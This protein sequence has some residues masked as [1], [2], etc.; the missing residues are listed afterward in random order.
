MSARDTVTNYTDG[1]ATNGA[2]VD[3]NPA[4]NANLKQ[5]QYANTPD[6]KIV[7]GALGV[8]GF[9]ATSHYR[10]SQ[11]ASEVLQNNTDLDTRITNEN[12]SRE[13]AFSDF[14]TRIANETTSRDTQIQSVETVRNTKFN[15]ISNR[16]EGEISVRT[17]AVDGLSG[18]VSNALSTFNSNS[19]AVT[20]LYN[21]L[22]GNVTSYKTNQVQ[23]VFTANYNTLS[24]AINTE[25]TD[26]SNAISREVASR[27]EQYESIDNNLS[28]EVASRESIYETLS[29]TI[30]STV[31]DINS[32]IAAISAD[33]S[34]QIS[35]EVST[36]KGEDN[37]INGR[38]DEVSERL[39]TVEGELNDR[40]GNLISNTDG[41]TIDSI[42]ELLTAYQGADSSIVG[43]LNTMVQ[44]VN[45]NNGSH[46]E[47]LDYLEKFCT[48]ASSF[49][50]MLYSDNAGSAPVE[51]TFPPNTANKSVYGGM[52]IDY[53]QYDHKVAEPG[54]HTLE[55]TTVE[56]VEAAAT[57]AVADAAAE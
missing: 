24:T 46:D 35:D 36:R 33:F 43:T 8:A 26:R 6:F 11:L 49:L 25:K 30:T 56:A 53:T 2:L 21:A 38:I 5:L 31:S 17:V 15:Q 48:M 12:T 27:S 41:P 32:D 1:D 23:N 19:T 16:L 42:S 4:A 7:K 14:G 3:V 45:Q 57:S 18:R 28:K 29:N 51:F 34:N 52:T 50:H 37:A 10:I 55:E 13:G 44:N 9:S 47:R 39:S 40:I 22:D 54:Y 20:S